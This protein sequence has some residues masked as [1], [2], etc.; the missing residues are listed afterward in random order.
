LKNI[1]ADEGRYMQILLNFLSNS[2][3]FTPQNGSISVEATPLGEE[4][5]QLIENNI[6][7]I[8]L[9]DNNESN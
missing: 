8:A 3:K 4:F 2:F 6:P 1:N 5:Y 9:N 7:F